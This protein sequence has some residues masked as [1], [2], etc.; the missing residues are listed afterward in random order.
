[1]KLKSRYGRYGGCY[2]PE[3]L[4]PI[5]MEIEAGFIKAKEDQSFQSEFQD[6]LKNY[7]GRETPVTYMKNLSK[8]YGFDLYLKR[9]D[10]LHGGAHKT[11]NTIG[12]LLLAKYLGKKRIIA[13]TGAGQHGVATAMTGAMLGMDV[14]IYMGAVD[15]A[16]QQPNVERMKL[17]G[18]KVHSVSSGSA[19]LKDAINDAMRDWITHAE[20]TYYCFGTAAGPYP[21]PEIVRYFQSVIGQE[22]KAQMLARTGKLPDAIIACVG[23]GSN[24]IG[25]F[26]AFLEDKSV[27]IYGAEPAGK[28]M[29]TEEHAATMNRGVE[30]VFH[31][32]QSLFL[33]NEDGQIKEPYSISAGLDYPGIG[34]EHAYL[35]SISRVNYK[36]ITDEEAICAFEILSKKEGIIPAFESSHALALA[37]KLAKE[38]LCGKTVLVNLSGRGD[39]DLQSYFNYRGEA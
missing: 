32:M 5:L 3:S 24:A 15:I 21:F 34:P 19:T 26:S 29:D 27:M 18:A 17:F 20:D 4:M 37:L 38:T 14:E 10:L 8:A 35:Q 9:E 30:G 7:A 12:Q 2:A 23:G 11:N 16:R 33:Q 22:A 28:G 13:E 31:G 25:L 36:T 1:M 39:K 6:L